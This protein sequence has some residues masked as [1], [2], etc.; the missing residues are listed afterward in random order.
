MFNDQLLSC[1]SNQYFLYISIQGKSK[2]VCGQTK[3]DK[4]WSYGEV[5]QMALLTPEE[6]E[7]FE[8]TMASNASESFLN[9]KLVSIVQHTNNRNI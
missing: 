3:C 4:E 2:F 6:M 9:S 7:Y 8:K 1:T 5:C